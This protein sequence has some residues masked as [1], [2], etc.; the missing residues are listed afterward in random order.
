[1]GITISGLK[2]EQGNVIGKRFETEDAIVDVTLEEEALLIQSAQ[3]WQRVWQQDGGYLGRT[4]LQYII[5]EADPEI[6]DD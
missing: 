2:D 4:L 1:M 5:Y 6:G 3:I